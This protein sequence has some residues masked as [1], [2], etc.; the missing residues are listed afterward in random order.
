MSM[1]CAV[2][3]DP[4]WAGLLKKITAH[5]PALAFQNNNLPF[6]NPENPVIL[7]TTDFDS[8]VRLELPFN[9]VD[10]H[11]VGNNAPFVP[12]VQ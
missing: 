2:I 8:G 3:S 4:F 10:L 1:M 12:F 6:V 5:T 11:L 7:K 9:K